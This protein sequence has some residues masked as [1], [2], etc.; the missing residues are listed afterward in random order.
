MNDLPSWIVWVVVG[1]VLFLAVAA[2]V[3]VA[4]RDRAIRAWRVGFFFERD[5]DHNG[6]DD[7]PRG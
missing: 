4:G 6:H 2:A 5:R 7:F 1:F 3:R